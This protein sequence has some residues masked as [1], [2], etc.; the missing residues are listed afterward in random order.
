MKWLLFTFLPLIGF[1]QKL[2]HWE[3]SSYVYSKE[4]CGF[5]CFNTVSGIFEKPDGSIVLQPYQK[6]ILQFKSTKTIE[7]ESAKKLSSSNLNNYFHWQKLDWYCASNGFIAIHKNKVVRTYFD[8]CKLSEAIGEYQLIND[9]LYFFKYGPL[10][11]QG[12]R[13]YTMY[14][15]DGKKIQRLRKYNADG[16]LFVI[17][18]RKLYSLYSLKGKLVVEQIRDHSILPINIVFLNGTIDGL[19]TFKSPFQFTVW[20]HFGYIH[21]I[22]GKTTKTLK[23]QQF[24]TS[25]IKGEYLFNNLPLYRILQKLS[26]RNIAQTTQGSNFSSLLFSSSS[27]SY[28]VGTEAEL[29]RIFPHVRFYPRNYYENN[30][31]STFTLTQDNEGNIWSGSYQGALTVTDGEKILFTKNLPYKWLAQGLVLQN[32]ILL[33][34]ETEKGLFV[35]NSRGSHKEFIDSVSVFSLYASRN[36]RLYLGTANKGLWSVSIDGL[37]KKQRIWKKITVKNGLEQNNIIAI[38]EDRFGNIWTGNSGSIAVY[39]PKTG[40]CKTWLK[41]DK[42]NSYLGA[43]S[44]LTDTDKNLWFGSVNGGLYYYSGKNA[45]DLDHKKLQ[46]IHHP[47]LH[48][49]DPITFLHQWRQHLLIGAQDKVLLFDLKEWKENRKIRIRYLNPMELNLQGTTEQNT[50]LTDFRDNTFWFSTSE[51]IYRVDVNKWFQ[52]PKF[53]IEPSLIV[54]T[55]SSNQFNQSATSRLRLKAGQNSFKVSVYYQSKD[56]MPRYLNGILT[57]QGERP[58]FTVPNLQ[59]EFNYTNLES[60]EYVFYVRVCQQDGSYSI[61]QF[62]I[63]IE[64]YIWQI[65]WFWVLLSL[66][67]ITLIG[68]IFWKRL[69]LKDQEKQVA[70]LSLATLSNQFRPHYMLNALNGIS[71][72]LEGKPKAEAL[73]NHLGESIDLLFQSARSNQFTHSFANEWELVQHMIEIQRLLYLP[74]LK[75]TVTGIEPV[76]INMQVPTGLIQIPVENA[77]LH[78]LRHKLTGEKQLTILVEEQ[79]NHFKITITD[80][81][82]GRGQAARI[83]NFKQHGS[84]L[85]NI[86]KMIEIINQLKPQSLTFEVFDL[87]VGTE[88]VICLSK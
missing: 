51:N 84:G 45:N 73:I 1:S 68:Y 3:S 36:H 86:E 5:D 65:W 48:Y 59:H 55:D 72:Q 25:R 67:P 79:Q 44:I 56:N 41:D 63:V 47:L 32:N 60:G 29:L 81:G 77:L 38:G 24:T 13:E 82:V 12:N 71:A 58:K 53:K 39:Q 87:K 31:N 54:S 69:Q 7:I 34:T 61:H 37:E 17:R 83:N 46:A 11:K 16:M 14:L 50:C 30:S 70:Q 43:R 9:K 35:F 8:I 76:P 10:S 80:N 6:T 52:V 26:G 57:R 66:I 33:P 19:I 49:G 75:F 28:Y 18:N 78:G 40:Y 85:S 23:D 2:P 15:F 22:S 4:K 88:V 21:K 74:D 64:S 42:P 62:P 20:N 27:N